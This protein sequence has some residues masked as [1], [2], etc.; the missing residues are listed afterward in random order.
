MTNATITSQQAPPL[1]LVHKIGWALSIL[2]PLTLYFSLQGVEGL[3]PQMIGF[4]S[5]TLWAV[6]CWAT[7]ILPPPLVAI[8]LP[9]FYFASGILP[10]KD[11]ARIALAAP[12]A[13][14]IPWAVIGALLIGI[15]T[16]KTGLARRIVLKCIMLTGSTYGGL[17]CALFVSG[18]ILRSGPHFPTVWRQI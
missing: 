6:V 8:I 3:T 5:L 9:I 15:I 1:S 18:L 4:L 17:L 2:L 7:E 11:A 16:Q 13:T 12:F 10:E 14:V